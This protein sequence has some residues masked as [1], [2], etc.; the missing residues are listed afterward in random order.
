[1]KNARGDLSKGNSGSSKKC[2]GDGNI[3]KV[4]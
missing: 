4:Q 3:S 2:S 1:L